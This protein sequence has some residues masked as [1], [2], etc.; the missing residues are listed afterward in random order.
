MPRAAS[1]FAGCADCGYPATGRSDRS[2]NRVPGTGQ[3]LVWSTMHMGN[4][5]SSL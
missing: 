1:M 4:E 5:G 2:P 3:A